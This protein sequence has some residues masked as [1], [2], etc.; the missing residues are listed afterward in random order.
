INNRAALRALTQEYARLQEEM[1]EGFR[2]K[3]VD[4]NYFLWEVGIFGPPDTLYAGGYFRAELCFPPDYPFSPPSMKFLSKI[5][6]PNIYKSGKVCI[7]VLQPPS[8]MSMVEDH[9]ERWNPTQNV[10]TILL[11]VILLLNEPNILSPANG[12]AAFWYR[13]HC[14]TMGAETKYRD[15]VLKHVWESQQYAL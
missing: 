5:W 4:D 14:E 15:M 9:A 11:S 13:R 8:S 12:I 6:H 2:V 3:L 1:L 10:R 7:S